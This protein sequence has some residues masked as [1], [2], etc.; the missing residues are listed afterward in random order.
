M[1]GVTKEVTLD[2]V[3][4]GTV[5]GMQGDTRAGFSATTTINRQDWGVS[6]SKTLDSGGLVVSNDV[7]IALEVEAIQ[8][9]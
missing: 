6:W 4:N 7:K 5:K 1:R 9:P 3:F 8:K 2:A